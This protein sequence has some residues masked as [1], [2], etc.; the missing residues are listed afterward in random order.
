MKK[1]NSKSLQKTLT[2]A[3]TMAALGASLGVPSLALGEVQGTGKDAQASGQSTGIVQEKQ[4][5]RRAVGANQIKW[6]ANQMKMDK[7]Q[8]PGVGNNNVLNTQ[9]QKR[10][11]GKDRKFNATF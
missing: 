6:E 3:A 1:S 5:Q 9:P 8:Q 11:R 10:Q 7:T 4:N 2:F